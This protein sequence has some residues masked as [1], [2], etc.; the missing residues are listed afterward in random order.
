MHRN[1]SCNPDAPEAPSV[2]IATSVASAH[3][4]DDWLMS[5]DPGDRDIL[6]SGSELVPL[7]AGQFLFRKGGPPD[8]FYGVVSGSVKVSTLHQDG[9]E[10]ILVLL[11]PG[12]WF[13]ELSMIDGLPRMHDGIA[14]ETSEVRRVGA[15]LFD[16][17]MHRG[18]FARSMALLQARHIRGAYAFVE[19]ATLR[20]TRA[21][22][23]RRLQRLARGDAELGAG[24]D[25]R[26]ISITHDMLAM[27]LGVTRQTLSLELKALAASGAI[28][29]QYRRIVIASMDILKA[30][31][32][33]G[34]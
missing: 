21:R 25:R 24:S 34:T 19:D 12:N 17:L 29:L 33:E 11:E 32:R 1:L 9:R 28:D 18:S 22:L 16:R 26:S 14:T 2:A 23:A 10:A 15:A 8:G 20:T 7:H 31:G 3:P 5:L 30:I 13:A 6:L 27:M 4:L